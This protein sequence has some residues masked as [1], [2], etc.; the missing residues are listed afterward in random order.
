MR[1]PRALCLERGFGHG[2][3]SQPGIGT[4]G[5]QHLVGVLIHPGV[6]EGRGQGRFF[7]DVAIGTVP[8]DARKALE[9]DDQFRIALV[10]IASFQDIQTLGI[11]VRSFER[12][13]VSSFAQ[14][15]CLKKLQ[16]RQHA[17]FEYRLQMEQKAL[18][19]DGI[20]DT[21]VIVPGEAG[22]LRKAHPVHR[23]IRQL[24]HAEETD[25]AYSVA[26]FDC[27]R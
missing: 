26:N 7:N 11:G 6:I 16:A 5:F 8:H 2:Q 24:Q 22:E 12:F 9:A 25:V 3:Y 18:V 20:Q 10:T 19:G 13:F 21:V 23:R 4:H 17:V 14:M 15:E 1:V 27:F